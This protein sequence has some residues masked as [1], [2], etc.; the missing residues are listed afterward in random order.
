MIRS[1]AAFSL[2]LAF[3]LSLASPAR[4]Q[5]P[6]DQPTRLPAFGK[7]AVSNDDSSALVQNPANIAFLPASELRWSSVY[8]NEGSRAA[9]QGHAL[10]FAFPIPFLNASTGLRVDLM[11]PPT[12][13]PGTL[14]RS[15][16]VYQWITW[17]LAIK[18]SDSFGLGMSLQRSYSDMREAHGLFG[19]SVG[20]TSRPSDYFGMAF[21]AHDING[22]KNDSGGVLNRS[23]D[24]AL[25]VRPL[26]SRALEVGL[27]GKI[28]D[29]P[30][31]YWSPSATLG[32][33][34]PELGRLRGSF[35]VVDPDDG[36]SKSEWLAS[37]SMSFYLNGTAGSMELGAGSIFGG[38]LG[39][40]VSGK[41]H[42][43]LT[44]EFAFK[45][46][47][48][49]SGTSTPGYA[50]RIR[51][52][53]TPSVR[54][55]TALLRHLWQVAEEEDSV[56][57][58]V[59]E[60]RT[61]PGSSIAHVQELR[62]A[63]YLLRQAGKKVLCHLEDADGASL[64]LCSAADRI[65]IN[66]AGG[67]RF[68]GLR[69]RY[70]Y[71]AGLLE[72]LGIKADFVRI[73]AHKSAPEAFTRTGASD[74]ARD[75]KIDLLQ[76]HE[77]QLTLGIAHGRKLTAQQVRERIAKG[78]FVSIEAK[79][80][81]FVD[82]YAFD[83]ELESQA[84]LLVGHPVRLIDDKRGPI[85]DRFNGATPGIA[86]VY[87]DGDMVDGRSQTIP[88]LGMKLAGSYTIAESIK[89]ARENPLV[90]AV[91]LRVE[92]GGG[93]AMAADVIWR[94][95]ERTTK[96]K[97]VIVSMGSAAASGGYYISSPATRVFANPLT[98]T[99]SIGIFYG[100]A[101]VSELLRKLG[102]SV[103]VYKTAPRAD[104]ESIFRPFTDEEKVE[105]KRKVW[106]FYDVFL[107]R[108][109]DGR[110]LTKEQVDAVGQG[111]VWTGEQALQHKL[112]DELG[113]LRQA[114]A[115]ART[116]AGLPDHA[117]IQELPPP[118]TSLI[119]RILGIEGV[120]ENLPSHLQVLPPGMMDLVRA[121]GPFI[122]HPAD[123]PLARM[124]LT[125]VE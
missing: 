85:A 50:L 2:G 16:G 59:L 71:Y 10:G 79:T 3:A 15:S 62:D 101:D 81:G 36:I 1:T 117:P 74:T 32:L 38:A 23:F 88:F 39:R 51:L 45:G 33:D 99:G 40:N 91:V 44:T 112:V 105:L 47:R 116:M 46:Y 110:K 103:E 114:L 106:Q 58:V 55:H 26:R 7:N 86:I 69:A 87:V 57:A 122:F 73:G 37:A 89:K 121:L 52:E 97:P 102:V 65:L 22:P 17:G 41:A 78:P 93:S 48:E 60:L 21:V 95:L 5:F 53:S 29:A 42:E 12:G 13:G 43:N 61:A 18:A 66:P 108:V 115:A 123:K 27:S 80:A 49:P 14:F 84:S 82:G 83:D 25:A 72:K 20:L 24:L 77:K 68:A 31:A 124:E 119:G 70:F 90:G 113:G 30:D 34:I 100:K 35:G 96:V 9:W 56:S 4:A 125:R 94:E 19:W 64:Y 107:Q 11:A 104:A 67:L 28:I 75:D 98:I 76:Q 8:L 120:S 92:T 6:T 54:E 63:V 118:D 111:R 109:A